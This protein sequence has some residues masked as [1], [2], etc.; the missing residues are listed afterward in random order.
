MK[1]T[2]LLFIFFITSCSSLNNVESIKK[3]FYDNENC[4]DMREFEIFQTLDDGA[5]AFLCED[6]HCSAY[7]QTVFLDNLHNVFY[8]DGMKVK[9]PNDKCAVVDGVYRYESKDERI[10]TVPIIKFQYKN[11]PKNEDEVK[12]RLSEAYDKIYD[13]CIIAYKKNNNKKDNS[14]KTC[15]CFTDAIIETTLTIYEENKEQ[16]VDEVMLNIEKKCGKLPK[17]VKDI[18]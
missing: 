3:A 9:A 7:N 8:Y 17:N 2:L 14:E 5:L 13:K 18:I 16:N 15:S 6:G 11:Y 12:Q 10:R 1:K 4:S